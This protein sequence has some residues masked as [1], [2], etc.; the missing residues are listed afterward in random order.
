[1]D[2]T[3]AICTWNRAEL[4]RS[5]LRQMLSLDKGSG[6]DWEILVINN[7]CSDNTSEIVAQF[8]H[9][10]PVREIAERKQ[11][12][13]NARNCAVENARGELIVWTDD[14]VLVDSRFLVE[15][16]RL[17]T[18][19]RD[20]VFFGG[21]IEP[22]FDGVPPIWLV[23]NFEMIDIVF[24]A[25]DYGA[26]EFVID[27]ANPLCPF[28]ANYAVRR[29]V[30][31][32]YPYDPTLGRTGTDMI[33][34]DETAVLKA[35]LNSGQHGVWL[36]TVKVKHFIPE[37]RQTI[38]YIRAYYAGHGALMIRNS[39]QSS[40]LS[41]KGRPAWIWRRRLISELAFSGAPF[42]GASGA[43]GPCPQTGRHLAGR[44][45][46]LRTAKS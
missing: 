29:E 40:R 35:I 32:Q 34:A 20:A 42:H 15:Y 30:Q 28:G 11:G 16:Q 39:R 6:I 2:I 10:L 22:W 43:M 33:S 45:R 44:I 38:D 36:P 13:S 5:T 3:I 17:N 21:P 27:S 46:A 37:G 9:E 12:L 1:M 4:L 8:Q 26:E 19:H 14:D 41:F 24:A 31:R 23:D 7:N 18:L 25:R